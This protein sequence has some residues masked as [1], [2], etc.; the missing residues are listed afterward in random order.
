M[1]K[2][3]QFEATTVVNELGSIKK[4]WTSQDWKEAYILAGYMFTA[5]DYLTLPKGATIYIHFTG[6]SENKTILFEPLGFKGINGGPITIDYYANGILSAAGTPIYNFNRNPNK[7]VEGIV[8][9]S[10]IQ[11]LDVGDISFIGQKFQG[12]IIPSVTG[13]G[14]SPGNQGASSTENLLVLFTPANY[15]IKLVNTDTSNDVLLEY[16][17]DWIETPTP[18]DYD[19]LFRSLE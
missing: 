12:E 17:F 8:S 1:L 13:L 2:A 18:L 16:Y 3:K 9:T 14:S 11:F 7:F 6:N 19:N 15:I 5:R 10:T 4:V